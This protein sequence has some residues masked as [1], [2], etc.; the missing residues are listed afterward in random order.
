MRSFVL[1]SMVQALKK[2][3][4]VASSRFA[5][6]YEEA[7]AVYTQYHALRN[8]LI[9]IDAKAGSFIPKIEFRAS[10]DVLLEKT[11]IAIDQMLGYL[12]PRIFPE[13][14]NLAE[15]AKEFGILRIEEPMSKLSPIL[16]ALGLSNNWAV[17]ASALCLI[18]V[19]VNRKLMELGLSS[20]GKFE[21]RVKR[22]SSKAKEKS[23][24]LPDL[25]APAFYNVRSKVIHGGKEPTPDELN[26]ILQFLNSFLQ[27]TTKLK[28]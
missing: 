18:E 21:D 9:S 24:D 1:F 22:L 3:A 26:T 16:V 19:L 20:K 4:E 11:K 2:S 25:L 27:K 17:A 15:W 8:S 6:S 14:I 5:P 28:T 10:A 23:V 12:Y 7:K 13:L